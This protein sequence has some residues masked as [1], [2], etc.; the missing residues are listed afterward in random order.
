MN[1]I[2]RIKLYYNYNDK[3][4]LVYNELKKLLLDNG[5]IIDDN[6]YDLAIA[7]G[8]DGGFLR[9]VSSCEYNSD[10]Y[11]VGVNTG[12]LGFS[13][14]INAD[15]L[16]E[17]VNDLKSFNFKVVDTSIVET[18]V[19]YD[20][21]V[22]TY[23][24]LNETVI[25]E[26]DLQTFRCDVFVDNVNLE[27]FI[28]DGFLVCSSFGSTAYNLS[29]GGSILYDGVKAMILT[30]IAPIN[31]KCYRSLINSIVVPGDKTIK[32][33]PN[34]DVILS[35]DG[36]NVTYNKGCNIEFRINKN[37]KLLRYNDYDYTKKINE[38]FSN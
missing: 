28:G 33:V 23:Y 11:Y 16:E 29:L 18:K 1:K 20:E 38:K 37:I 3:S 4:T 34:N 13:N 6:N 36:V 9:L 17:F 25:R 21:K 32:I 15:R 30:P 14:D 19:Y 7:I 22:K 26:R 8:G 27:K 24:S 31:N 35:V 2:S 5:F 12:T 10:V